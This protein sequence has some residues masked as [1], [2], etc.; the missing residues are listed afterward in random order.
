MVAMVNRIFV[1]SVEPGYAVLF[2]RVCVEGWDVPCRFYSATINGSVLFCYS[3]THS[4]KAAEEN[5]CL[6]LQSRGKLLQSFHFSLV[7][8]VSRMLKTLVIVIINNF[9]MNCAPS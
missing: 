3:F 4:L 2:V 7:A 5:F 1:F 9:V 8:S 6:L